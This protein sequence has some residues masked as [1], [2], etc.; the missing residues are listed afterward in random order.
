MRYIDYLKLYINS[1]AWMILAAIVSYAI[2]RSFELIEPIH[3]P[4]GT[5]IANFVI[6]MFLAPF[7]LW[8]KSCKK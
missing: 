2:M 8:R 5:I 6:P 1:S 3:I 7:L 4:I